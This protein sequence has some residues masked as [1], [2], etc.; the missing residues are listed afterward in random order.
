MTYARLS[1]TE[2]EVKANLKKGYLSRP[3]GG[4]RTRLSIPYLRQI[5]DACEVDYTWL[6]TGTGE[7]AGLQR[8]S[9][10]SSPAPT[11]SVE[12]SDETQSL[13]TALFRVMDPTAF[14][15]ADFLAARR[16]LVDTFAYA[17]DGTSVGERALTALRSA[18][19]LR[20]DGLPVHT[21]SILSRAA[22]GRIP[23]TAQQ[24]R[25]DA[26]EQRIAAKATASGHSK[27]RKSA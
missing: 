9:P 27:T 23:E 10:P 16:A 11:E 12:S 3:L 15:E 7:M 21:A 8:Q 22:F 17:K 18:R 14:T 20:L 24:A 13:V 26:N 4:G 25:V 2:L 5:A 19:S 1:P 6:S